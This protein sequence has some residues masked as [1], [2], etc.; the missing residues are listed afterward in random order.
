MKTKIYLILSLIAVF[1]FNTACEQ[2][3][4]DNETF[5]TFEDLALSFTQTAFE[6]SVPQEDISLEIPVS[7]S[8]TSSETRTFSV[9]VTD[10]TTVGTEGEYSIGT[11]TIPAGEYNGILTVD[12]DFS[13]IGGMDGDVKKLV[14]KLDSVGDLITYSDEATITYF[15]EIVCND[16]N[17]TIVSDVWATETYWTLEQG[18]GTVLV[19]RFFPFG[20]NSL[21]PQTY[22][23]DFF[24]PDG[25][26]VLKIG[27]VFGDGMVGSAAGVT[28]EGN[29]ALTCSI[30]THASGGPVLIS[31]P[32]P[33]P[34]APNA[35][36]EVTE[37][38][39]NP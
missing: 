24:L 1:V 6:L 4:N 8:T 10:A 17:L 28:L 5:L 18:D 13:E 9:S 29:Y 16:L 32:D 39:V 23:F 3:D 34:G 33:F 27:D 19:N 36:V 30:I 7:V 38:T 31:V 21:S 26:Y 22:T 37:F 11:I 15:R 25:D 14:L 35:I 2:E 20:I 12:F